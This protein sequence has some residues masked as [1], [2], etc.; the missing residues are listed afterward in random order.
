METLTMFG[1]RV[2][3]EGNSGE[4]KVNRELGCGNRSEVP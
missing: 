3:L 4:R 2:H 1:T